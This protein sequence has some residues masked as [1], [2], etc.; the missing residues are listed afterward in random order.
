MRSSRR[1]KLAI[2][3]VTLRR[4]RRRL[5]WFARST[6]ELSENLGKALVSV[7]SLCYRHQPYLGQS[8]GGRVGPGHVSDLKDS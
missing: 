7:Y 5:G 3:A 1:F 4:R 6:G 2:T 8:L